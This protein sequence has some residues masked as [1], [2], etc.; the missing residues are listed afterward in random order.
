MACMTGDFGV[1][2]AR[3]FVPSF[4]SSSVLLFLSTGLGSRSRCPCSCNNLRR[5]GYLLTGL[6][7]EDSV[8]GFASCSSG[9]AFSFVGSESGLVVR[10]GEGMLALR[11]ALSLSTRLSSLSSRKTSILALSSSDRSSTGLSFALNTILNPR[12]L[13]VRPEELRA[14]RRAFLRETI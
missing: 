13:A 5:A 4:R 7:S 2:K 8:V 12:P 14:I 10:V 6:A 11:I 9:G 1:R 3:F